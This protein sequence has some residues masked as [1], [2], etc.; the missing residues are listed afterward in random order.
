MVLVL[1]L[2]ILRS[3]AANLLDGLYDVHVVCEDL[4]LFLLLDVF[5]LNLIIESR[6]LNYLLTA[7][8]SFF[9]L[10]MILFVL[11]RNWHLIDYSLIVFNFLVLKFAWRGNTRNLLTDHYERILFLLGIT[12]AIID[13]ISQKHFSWNVI[14]QFHSLKLVSHAI[15]F[16]SRQYLLNIVSLVNCLKLNKVDDRKILVDKMVNELLVVGCHNKFNNIMIK[17]S[18]KNKIDSQK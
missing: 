7:G 9:L 13:L 8:N 10:F 6:H 1:L 15:C 18:F 17:I 14:Q 16:Y 3:G 2:R 4:A 5:A 12:L 11:Y